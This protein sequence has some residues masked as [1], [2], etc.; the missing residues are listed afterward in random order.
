[1]I[2]DK[3]GNLANFSKGKG[4]SKNDL[5][6]SGFQILLYGSLYTNYKIEISETNTYV[7]DDTGAVK[8]KGHEVVV[9]S[10][11]ETPDEIARASAITS[12]DIIIGG[13]LNIV[14][15]PFQLNSI[16]LA[17]VL[18][19]GKSQKELRKRAQGATITHLR[20]SDLTHVLVSYPTRKEQDIITLFL[21]RLDKIIT[22]EQKKIEKLELLKQ[23]LLQ[24]MFANNDGN[25]KLRFDNFDE[26]WIQCELGEILDKRDEKIIP[27]ADYP[28]MSFT[29]TGGI[30]EKGDRY[31]RSFLVK[32]SNKKYKATEFNDLIYSSNNLDV[33]AIGLNKFGNACISVVYEIFSIT[34][35]NP[36]VI[37]YIVQTP[38]ILHKIISYR[39]GALY[40]QYKIH[41][42]DFL[43]V[44]ILIPKIAEQE[45]ISNFI[46]NLDSI[47][48]L[49]QSKLMEYKDLK[50]KLL[51]SLFI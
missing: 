35:N 1:W 42:T 2:Q 45:K 10:S 7:S 24:N 33:G 37:S 32:N 26:E 34:N 16:F 31:D 20:N 30:E 19:F 13:D 8:S 36:D 50:N 6:S 47:I 15:P 43:K 12:K 46:T 18:T 17:V 9:P 23:Y 11:G 48:T 5:V 51:Q 38:R 22:L 21:K 14:L 49:E 44:N 3:L 39:Q 29:S 25:P 27:N 4:Y 40:G 41:S 28:L